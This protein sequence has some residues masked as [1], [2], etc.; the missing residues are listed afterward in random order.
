MIE[1]SSLEITPPRRRDPRVLRRRAEVLSPG[2]RRI[3]V[4]QRPG[5]LSSLEAAALLGD[6][7]FDPI[8]HL[9]N[10]GR[11]AR[12]IRDEIERAAIAG[13]HRVLCMR[14][15]HTAPDRP[16]TPTLRE[17]VDSVRARLPGAEIGVTLNPYTERG[18][19]LRNLDAKLRAGASFVQTQPVVGLQA[20]RPFAEEIRAR[21]PA[22]K[23]VPM[24]MPFASF[25]VAE[26]IRKRIRMPVPFSLLSDL[27]AG[28]QE[29]GWEAFADTLFALRESPLVD[30]V[31]MMTPT[32]DPGPAVR[33]RLVE[34]LGILS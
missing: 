22:V 27:R 28:D 16:D 3:D 9:V 19:A 4:I 8:W 6:L 25:D 24:V 7:G 15:D 29:A 21:H 30:G 18:P 31:A 14:G 23:I 2:L 17:T 32:M 11:G 26:R 5:R 10:R 1:W 20:L 13:L 12:A 34:A 33:E